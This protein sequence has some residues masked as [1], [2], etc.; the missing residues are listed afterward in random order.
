MNSLGAFVFLGVVIAIIICAVV[1]TYTQKPTETT[2]D[3]NPPKEE[4]ANETND[5]CVD[6]SQKTSTDNANCEKSPLSVSSVEIETSINDLKAQI[7]E[8]KDK[9]LSTVVKGVLLGLLLW[10][11]IS[12][13]VGF[14]VF[15]FYANSHHSYY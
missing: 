12:G 1:A 8:L 3:N 7:K 15:V 4:S 13:F 9:Q 2:T 6:E 5:L 10:S 14:I 11:F